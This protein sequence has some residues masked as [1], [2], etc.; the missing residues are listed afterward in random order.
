MQTVSIINSNDW[1]L[2]SRFKNNWR[3]LRA[4][5]L[6]EIVFI[7]YISLEQ[8]TVSLSY[9]IFTF[10]IVVNPKY[11]IAMRYQNEIFKALKHFSYSQHVRYV[12]VRL[13]ISFCLYCFS[14][15]G[16]QLHLRPFVNHHTYSA[17]NRTYIIISIIIRP[18]ITS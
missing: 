14:Y 9:A 18:Y 10:V 13:S 5:K 12:A 15:N 1:C 11:S 7:L 8:V 17:D 2:H 4:Y 16:K 6:T 3:V